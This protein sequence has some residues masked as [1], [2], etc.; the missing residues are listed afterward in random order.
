MSLFDIKRD[1]YNKVDNKLLKYN[2]INFGLFFACVFVINDKGATIKKQQGFNLI[3]LMIVVAIIGILAAVAI[4]AYQFNTVRA[5][6]SE[7]LIQAASAKAQVSEAFI[8]D[9]LPAVTGLATSYNAILASEKATKYV[10]DIQI[11]NDGVVTVTLTNS[12]SS[13]FP[14]DALGTTLVL[15]P[16]VKGAKIAS[17]TGSVDWACASTTNRNATTK[18]LVANLGTLPAKYAP[19]E[20]R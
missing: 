6:I 1:F 18:G 8:A 10:D 11:D 3:E 2:K 12:I 19:P 4:P 9:G 13:G 5:K 20:C 17:D 16:N 14:T 7:A 15:T